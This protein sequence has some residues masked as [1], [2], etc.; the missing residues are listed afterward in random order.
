MAHSKRRRTEHQKSRN[1]STQAM[2]AGKKEAHRK[3][4]SDKWANDVKYQEEQKKRL[5]RLQKKPK[6]KQNIEDGIRAK[7]K[8]KEQKQIRNK[9]L[10]EEPKRRR[11]K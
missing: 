11:F 3:K 7:A 10:K 5:E 4:E 6:Y 1:K 9:Q 8:N 2:R